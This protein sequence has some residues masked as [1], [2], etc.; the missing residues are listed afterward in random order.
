MGHASSMA[1]GI[2]VMLMRLDALTESDQH[3]LASFLDREETERADGIRSARVRRQYIATR[4]TAR[5]SLALQ[6]GQPLQHI[7]FREGVWGKPYLDAMPGQITCDF[8]I[9]HSDRY[10]AIALGQPATSDGQSCSG[11]IGLDIETHQQRLDIDSIASC[12]LTDHEHQTF[13][14]L[15]HHTAKRAYFLRS[16]TLKEAV[17][18]SVGTG[19]VTDLKQIFCN[20]ASDISA[21]SFQFSPQVSGESMLAWQAQIDTD[22]VLSLAVPKS[23]GINHVRV[24]QLFQPLNAVENVFRLHSGHGEP[25]NQLPLLNLQQASSS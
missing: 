6:T 25:V 10:V 2:E 17:L 9:S 16:W 1:D 4:A 11:C 5:V 15:S 14:S 20:L 12:S 8:N 23:S 3:R 19:L 7:R 13:Q 21:F 18:K 22:T 24:R